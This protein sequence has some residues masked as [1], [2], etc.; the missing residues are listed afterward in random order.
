MDNALQSILSKVDLNNLPVVPKVLLDLI[1]STQSIEVR[2]KDLAC[3]IGQD[4]SL[5]AKVLATANSSFYRQWGEITDLNRVIIVLGLSTVKTIAVTRSVQQYFSQIPRI[6]HESL[7]LIWYRSLTCAHLAHK[8]AK[9][10][11]Y[12]FPE[13]S[14]LT[15]LLHR[16]G[17][18][19]LLECFPNDYPKF[20]EQDLDGRDGGLEKQLFGASH[21]EIGGYL[22]E[23]WNLQSFI[24]DAVCHQY[25]SFET[26]ADSSQ[27]VK[28]INL[29]GQIASID[30]ANRY[31]VL[32]FADR[33]FG[34]G[35][36]L[37]E[38]M[39]EEVG[40]LVRQ[41]ADNMGVTVAVS[42]GKGIKCLTTI[43]Q[44]EAVRKRLGERIKSLMLFYRGS[45]AIGCVSGAE[46]SCRRYSE[47]LE[48]FI[49]FSGRRFFPV[50]VRNE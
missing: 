13:E 8:L 24:S 43:Q 10:T 27:L 29:A 14:Y 39:I 48:R 46:Q 38:D 34:I 37:I 16:L 15:G 19:V 33:L 22:I 50:P 44:R 40:N 9:L 32:D 28:I 4:A 7:E 41:S 45:P 25:Q 35:Q 49:R 5:S 17:Q 36:P 6:K 1:R 30:T 12:P 47:G 11:S 3:I 2:F 20:L 31:D 42:E 18:L 21:N 26:I 23:T